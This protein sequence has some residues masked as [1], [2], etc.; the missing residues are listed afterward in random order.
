M[1]QYEKSTSNNDK[2]DTD[3]SDRLTGK[4][5]SR[6]PSVEHD[7]PP[8]KKPTCSET[9]DKPLSSAERV[10]PDCDAPAVTLECESCSLCKVFWLLACPF[11]ISVVYSHTLYP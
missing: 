4:R 1:H 6:S 10:S 2:L 11:V 9:S 7:M 5:T 3:D 8:A